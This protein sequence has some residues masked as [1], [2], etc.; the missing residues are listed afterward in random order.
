[1]TITVMGE[2]RA[3]VELR[4]DY[5]DALDKDIRAAA[6]LMDTDEIR[7]LVDHYYALQDLRMQVQHKATMV[8]KRMD[9]GT[10]FVLAAMLSRQV[11]L[12]RDVRAALAA[13]VDEQLRAFPTGPV[14]WS[15]GQVGI[16]PV[17]A[18]GLACYLPGRRVIV[19]GETKT[20]VPREVPPT[21]GHWWRHAG[22]DPSQE[23][24]KGQE[25]PWNA[26]LKVLCYKIGESFV[27]FSGN[28]GAFYGHLYRERKAWEM[29][30][31]ARG[32]NAETAAKALAKP[33]RWSEGQRERYASGHLPQAQIHA[34][35][36]RWAVKLFLAHYH[37]VCY[38]AAYG[39]PAPLPYVLEH[40]P[41]HAHKI[42]RPE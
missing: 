10:P 18:A 26:K 38:E 21:V 23:W 12:E 2:E 6:R 8:E 32:D 40:V 31:D 11:K 39:R 17:L 20:I 34:R 3:E 41:G 24:L 7:V 19:D 9:E 22:L 29:E 37:E 14:A 15:V 5:A 36:R 28:P 16:G 4:D 35:A 13:W 42:V 27:K 25:R 30:R 1:M 33:T